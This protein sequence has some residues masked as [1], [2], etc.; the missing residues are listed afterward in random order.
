MTSAFLDSLAAIPSTAG[1][2]LLT[3]T[4]AALLAALMAIVRPMRR[5]ISPRP[6]HVVQAQIL[7][8]I[9]GAAIMIIV[10]ESL[11]RAFAVVGAAGLVRYRARIDDPK[12]AGVMLVTLAVGLATGVGRVDFAVVAT[13][14]CLV[15]L[16]VL[17]FFEPPA[18]QRFDL[19][20]GT[21]TDASKMQPLVERLFAQKAVS[22]QLREVT[23]NDLHYDVTV[24]FNIKIRK[25]SRMIRKLDGKHNGTTVEWDLYAPSEAH[26]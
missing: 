5:T 26:Q 14:F 3:L 12:D 6:P 10:A 20:I 22:F 13:L 1:H 2:T 9:V 7:L 11:A 24:P 8:G 16:W 21:D 4:M 17:E 25:L 19:W 15:V 18:R 23:H